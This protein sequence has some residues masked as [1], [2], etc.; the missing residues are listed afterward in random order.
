MNEKIIL[1]GLVIPFNKRSSLQHIYTRE[2][3]SP[4]VLKE[5]MDRVYKGDVVGVLEQRF[6]LT[7]GTSTPVSEISHKVIGLEISDEGIKATLEV[8][9]TPRG[10][11][12]KKMIC[13]G[14]ALWGASR[15]WGYVKGYTGHLTEITT[16][17][18][19]GCTSFNPDEVSPLD[20]NG[21]KFEQFIDNLKN[22][23]R[24]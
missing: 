17:D 9:D 16:I 23:S 21:E 1:S 22:R 3:I 15:G 5:F 4:E 8:L 18:L 13:S 12:V 20:V 24:E 6:S 10:E 2:S 7:D 19:T 14:V 11:L